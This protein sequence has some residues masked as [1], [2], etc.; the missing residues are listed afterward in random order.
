[1]KLC[2][3]ACAATVLLAT[4]ASGATAAT[5]T[6][7]PTKKCYRDGEIVN[8]G[9]TG[10]TANNEVT[11]ARDGMVFPIRPVTD[12]TGAFLSLLTV[13][14]GTGQSRRR[15]T[16]TDVAN[17]TISASTS[18]VVS[19]IEVN[20]KPDTGTPGKLLRI[21]ARGF[22]TGK[23]LYAHIVR[24]G[25]S[26]NERIGRLRGACSKLLARKRLFSKKT[27]VGSY[28]VQFDTE[29]RYHS[30]TDVRFAFTVD[31]SL[32]PRASASSWRRTWSGARPITDR[33][34]LL[35]GLS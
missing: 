14:Q 15:Y 19:S 27:K 25:R 17:P 2:I 1:M 3:A 35:P 23:T 5:V 6:P 33:A 7:S 29:R 8:L 13:R 12:S 18:L 9:G 22:T 11:I 31:I 16:A 10:F 30:D 4:G 34:P 24:K 28:R 21:G 20:V 26:R 32:Q